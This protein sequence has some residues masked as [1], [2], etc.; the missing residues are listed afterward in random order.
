MPSPARRLM[1]IETLAKA[2]VEVRVMVAPVLPGLTDHEIDAI[3]TSAR[4]AG[5]VAASWV[6]LRLPYE[7]SGLFEDWLE[8]TAPGKK[9][10]VLARLREMHGGAEYSAQWHRRMRGEGH[11]AQLIAQRFDKAARRLGLDRAL[12][13]LRCDLFRVPARAGDQLSLF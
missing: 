1:A 9:A 3:L 10:K 11:Y 12:G 5:A 7:V 4:D 2:G 8:R 13:P 6:M